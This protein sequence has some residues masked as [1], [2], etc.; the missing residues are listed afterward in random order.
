[1]PQ[2][3]LMFGFPSSV[4]QITGRKVFFNIPKTQG[5]TFT[6][7]RSSIGTTS[8]QGLILAN[9]APAAASAQQY[10]PA[11]QL[12]GQ[13]WSTSNGASQPSDWRIQ[14]EPIQGAGAISSQ[15]NFLES[16]NGGSYISRMVLNTTSSPLL[17]VANVTSSGTVT[18][19]SVVC[20]DFATSTQGTA[21][22]FRQGGSRLMTFNANQNTIIQS[23]GSTS[24][25]A[26]QVALFSIYQQPLNPS[27][28]TTSNSAGGTT[29]TG[30]GTQFTNTFKVGDTITMAGET[31][32]ISTIT[33]DTLMT[34]GTWTN[35]HNPGTGYT[36]TGGI[37]FA[38]R[39]NGQIGIG[40][41]TPTSF[42]HLRAGNANLSQSPLKHTAGTLQ[43]TIE[44][45]TQEA[46]AS[47]IYQSSVALNRYALGGV[48]ADFTADVNNSG[49]GETDLLTYTTKA[50]TLA[51]TGEKLVFEA[52]GTFNDITATAQLQAYFAGTNIGNTGALTVSAT[53]VWVVRIIV[54]RTGA[55]TARASVFVHSPTASTVL[56][57]AETDLT[58]LTFSGTN[59]IKITGTAGG[60]GGG[61]SDITAKLG[62]IFWYGAANN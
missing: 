20:V 3:E 23:G 19:G 46:N 10:S 22:V 45:L 9:T 16:V 59:I 12:S 8:T 42:L 50:S 60:A 36:L 40:T 15:I 57:T 32:T 54:I 2:S 56:Y 53:G 25:P 29:V 58:S 38:V 4:E 49:T 41:N 14:V 13:G 11:L 31:Q 7:E 6:V 33:S 35:A 43:T 61:S 21:I 48:I 26:D 37:L 44:A 55:S 47:S 24:F 18:A 30:V 5:T 62:T 27:T 52:T 28:A 1:M 51:A 34:T 39:G 17:T